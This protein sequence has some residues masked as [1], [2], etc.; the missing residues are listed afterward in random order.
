MILRLLRLTAHL[1]DEPIN[2]T[3]THCFLYIC[4]GEWFSGDFYFIIFGHILFQGISNYI[5]SYVNFFYFFTI[6]SISVCLLQFPSS[7]KYFVSI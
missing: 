3:A 2:G 7:Y 5:H 6:L 4:A 1:S